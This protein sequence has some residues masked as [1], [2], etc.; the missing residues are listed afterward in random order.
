MNRLQM[1]TS[2][3]FY[4]EKFLKYVVNSPE[5]K[6]EKLGSEI[7]VPIYGTFKVMP[8]E[9]IFRKIKKIVAQSTK[10]EECIIVGGIIC[11]NEKGEEEIR[12]VDLYY[13][14]HVHAYLSDCFGYNFWNSDLTTISYG[15][16]NINLKNLYQ[17]R[18]N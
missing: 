2:I 1:N 3:V 4:G 14:P 18:L 17:L 10:I 6:S 5:I 7:H 15:S 8:K 16:K 11:L 13:H 9:E 12:I